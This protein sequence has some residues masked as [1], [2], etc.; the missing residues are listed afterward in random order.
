[1]E[2]CMC[3]SFILY[4]SDF[5]TSNGEIKATNRREIVGSILKFGGPS[6]LKLL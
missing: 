4:I 6:S 5:C 1:M 2:V 3:Q